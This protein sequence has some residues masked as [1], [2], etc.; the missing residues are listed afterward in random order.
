MQNAREVQG[1]G[2]GSQSTK[3]EVSLTAGLRDTS[4]TYWEE[5]F[6]APCLEDSRIP[7]M[8]GIKSLKANDALI[9]CRTG[10]IWFLGSGGVEIKASPGSRHFQMKEA[11]SGH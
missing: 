2:H 1:V 9:R 6:K 5:T 7:G 10:E 3:Y 4:G 11:P 8:M